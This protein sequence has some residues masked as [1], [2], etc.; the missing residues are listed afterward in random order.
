LFFSRLALSL[1]PEIIVATLKN[2]YGTQCFDIKALIIKQKKGA[3][4]L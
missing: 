2:E 4:R 1:Q 3:D